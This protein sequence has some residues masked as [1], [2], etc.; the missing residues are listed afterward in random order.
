MHTVSPIHPAGN[1]T[2]TATPYRVRKMVKPWSRK[3][4]EYIEQTDPPRYTTDKDAAHI[5]P[6]RPAAL[7]QA[8]L[9]RILTR[10]RHM[11]EP[12]PAGETQPAEEAQQ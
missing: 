12:V 9:M 11:I 2:A 1:Q 8:R 7:Y 5:F 10:R 4:R 6:D 3:P